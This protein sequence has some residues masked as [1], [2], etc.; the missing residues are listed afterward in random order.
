MN[1]DWRINSFVPA[2]GFGLGPSLF[3]MYGREPI[4]PAIAGDAGRIIT[5][6]RLGLWP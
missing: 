4:M 1:M 6:R 2:R 3:P 5:I